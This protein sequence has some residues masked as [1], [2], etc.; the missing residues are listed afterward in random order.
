MGKKLTTLLLALACMLG[1]ALSAAAAESYTD[2]PEGH[3]AAENIERARELGLFQGV[4]QG[5]FGMGQPLTRAA[6]QWDGVE[7]ETPTFEDVAPG[8][9]YYGAA[10][11]ALAHGAMPAVGSQFRPNDPITRE[12][13]AVMLVRSLDYASLAGAL[14]REECPFEDVHTNRG[15]ITKNKLTYS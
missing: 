4:G 6:F 11:A 5:R 13:M 14:S 12:E 1:L 7:P 9:W 10:E 2:V 3:W 15:Y 8:S